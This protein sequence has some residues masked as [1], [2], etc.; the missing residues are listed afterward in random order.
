MR[1]CEE[2]RTGPGTF[3]KHSSPGHSSPASLRVT[4]GLI[5]SDYTLF[6]NQKKRGPR[7]LWRG[8]LCS[9][10]LSLVQLSCLVLPPPCFWP[11]PPPA[12]EPSVLQEVQAGAEVQLR[13][14]GGAGLSRRKRH[15]VP[16]LSYPADRCPALTHPSHCPLP[17]N[18]P[19]HSPNR[20]P[21][22]PP[23][24]GPPLQ[25]KPL[26]LGLY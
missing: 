11:G 4:G 26:A 3:S 2:L 12:A 5:L 17:P 14:S 1:T 20:P 16:V 23:S 6:I 25:Q 15:P 21:L 24:A 19:E 7:L 10:N 9:S 13:S 8:P 18:F 22:P